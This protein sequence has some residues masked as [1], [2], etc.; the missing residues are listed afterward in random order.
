MD[1]IKL[2]NIEPQRLQAVKDLCL[3]QPTQDPG[4]DRITELTARLFNTEIALITIMTR[5]KQLFI[6]AF[7]TNIAEIPRQDSFCNEAIFHEQPLVIEDCFQ[8]K[9]FSELPLVKDAPFIRFYAGQPI[10]SPSGF[11]IGT[12][13]ILDSKPK[14]FE[15]NELRN[16]QDLAMIAEN[17]I[18]YIADTT[19]DDLTG[20][21]NRRGFYGQARKHL[22]LAMRSEL[23]ASLAI[24]DLNRFKDIN[25]EFGH[26]FGDRVLRIFADA[27]TQSTRKTDLVARFGGDEFVILSIDKHS[28]DL[29]KVRDRLKT[30]IAQLRPLDLPQAI[31]IDFCIGALEFKPTAELDLEAVLADAIQCIHNPT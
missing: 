14:K 16:L 29:Y 1:Q 5:D 13:C 3:T 12:L 20:L 6:S 17:Q 23:H 21:L 31:N 24:I 19:T 7:G 25:N 8:D 9:R 18:K 15:H 22:D 11:I 2:P 26:A 10:K 4:L 30:A 28:D 27:L